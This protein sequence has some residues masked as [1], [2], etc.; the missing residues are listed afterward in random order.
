MTAIDFLL[1]LFFTFIGFVAVRN[2]PLFVFGTFIPLVKGV[3]FFLEEVFRRY[4]GKTLKIS[5]F[6]FIIIFFMTLPSLKWKLENFG[7]G[8]GV[9]DETKHAIDFIKDNNIKSPMFNNYDIGNY[10]EYSLYPNQK[11]YLDNRPEAYPKEFFE[12]I[13]L[14]MQ[15]APQLFDIEDIKYN[16]NYVFLAHTDLTGTYKLIQK[17]INDPNWKMV[18]FNSSIV[19]FLKDIPS[20]KEMV[21]KY[22]ITQQTVKIRKTDI[23]SKEKIENLINFFQALGWLKPFLD[24]NIKYLD[25][26]SNNC[27]ALKN[28]TAIYQR[29]QNPLSSQYLSKYRETCR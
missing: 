19:I 15:K 26:D 3:T 17:L 5:V 2:F 13:Y 8:L 9:I 4:K 1:S 21:N 24:L 25:F 11:V 18:Y 29:E 22:S 14:P 23:N 28:V 20:N 6:L 10:L 7:F 27:T 16:F 12:R